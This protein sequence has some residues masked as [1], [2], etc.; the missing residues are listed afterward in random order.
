MT[1]SVLT[2]LSLSEIEERHNGRLLVVLGISLQDLVDLL[3]I[4]GGEIEGS[5]DIVVGRI[6]MLRIMPIDPHRSYLLRATYV[7]E[8]HRGL[9][10]TPHILRMYGWSQLYSRY[11]TRR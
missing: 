10:I 11:D 5:V 3:V 8:T 2:N 9:D 1:L 7:A 4:L 6:I